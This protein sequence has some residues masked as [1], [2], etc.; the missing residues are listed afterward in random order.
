M[1]RLLALAVLLL[2]SL[3][4]AADPPNIVLIVSD[5]HGWQDYGFMGHKGVRTPNLDKLASQ[6][7]VFPNGYVPTSLCRPS[8]ASM[9]TGMYPHQHK[10]CT[11]DQPTGQPRDVMWGFIRENP[12]IPRMLQAKGYHS[13]QTGKW[14]E[15]HHEAGGFT[16]GMTV[17]G[18]HGDDGLAI[19]RQTM[20]PM[21]D[22]I[23][24]EKGKPFFL[25]YAPMLPHMP[26]NPP[27]RLLA[28][29]QEQKLDANVAKYYAM[30]EWFDETCGQL[31]DYLEK[32]GLA[33]NTI[34]AYVADNGWIQ[35]PVSVKADGARGGAKGKIT[36]YDG[37]LRT[38]IMIKWAGH[39]KPGRYNDLVSSIDLAPTLVSAAG[40]APDAKMAG[41]NLLDVAAGKGKLARDQVFGETF[42]HSSL[43]VN[44]PAKNLVSRWT[45][46]GDWKLIVRVEGDPE[47]YNLAADPT[48]EKNLAKS[49]PAK[50]EE[51]KKSL[52]GWWKG[53]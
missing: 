6:S 22:F 15:G 23:E 27:Q 26:H 45:R 14:W 36:P 37:G 3:S 18:R 7:A 44:N 2:P 35:N 52:D 51:L 9:L 49:E 12:T 5:D 39:A 33:E 43:D 50:V 28:K 34:I 17:K 38:P 48:E 47:L 10:I 1:N 25:W 8:L 41:L 11:N 20:Q 13:F 19:G 31:M 30:I 40:I 53:E 24:K 21:W 42:I 16:A 46:K 4:L 29:Y 32:N